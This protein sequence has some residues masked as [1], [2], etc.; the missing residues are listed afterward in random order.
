MNMS[1][2][3]KDRV[4]DPKRTF[5]I[6][7]VWGIRIRL[8]LEGKTRDFPRFIQCPEPIKFQDFCPVRPVKALLN[9]IC[10]GLPGL[11][12]PHHP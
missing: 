5:Q 4:I 8:E 6:S 3:N 9:M 12:A 7:H 2:W 1:R 10:V 11:S